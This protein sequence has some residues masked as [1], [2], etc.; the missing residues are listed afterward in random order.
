MGV[1]M[2]TVHALIIDD[3]KDTADL[4]KTILSLVGYECEAVYS[5]KTALAYLATNEPDIILLDLRLGLELDGTDILH[6][7]RSNPRF[8]QT[9]VIVVTAFPRMLDQDDNMAD[10][11]LIKPIEVEDLAT[12]TSRLAEIRPRSYMYRDPATRLYSINFFMTRLEHAY[13][14]MKRHPES[15]FGVLAFDCLVETI[16]GQPFQ[17]QENEK[18][19]LQ[20]AAQLNKDFRPTDTFGYFSGQRLVALYEDFKR[21]DDIYAVI[22]RL[23]TDLTMDVEIDDQ[24][25]HCFPVIGAVISDSRFQNS[26]EII[27]TATDALN[28]L[29]QTGEGHFLVAAPFQT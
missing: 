14:R 23:K 29:R 6:Q 10:L 13:E 27:K 11:T 17:E 26:D 21:P 12:L 22:Q 5:A 8:D 2:A 24:V 15:L 9:R 20:L 19:I 16:D 3:D 1:P 18:V 4:F 7:V 28:R 25:Y